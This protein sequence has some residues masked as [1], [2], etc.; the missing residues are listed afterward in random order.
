MNEF[1]RAHILFLLDIALEFICFSLQICTAHFLLWQEE[2][3]PG[4]CR[5]NQRRPQVDVNFFLHY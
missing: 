2:K 5:F 1:L 3:K 4:G